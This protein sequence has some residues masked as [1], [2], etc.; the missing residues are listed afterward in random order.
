M[1]GYDVVT[2]DG[3]E[4]DTFRKADPNLVVLDHDA[5]ARWLRCLSRLRKESDVPIIMLTALGGP[6]HWAGARC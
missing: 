4:A 3:E 2:A 6:N 1:I 5:Q